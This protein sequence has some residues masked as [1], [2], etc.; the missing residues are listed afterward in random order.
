MIIPY[1]IGRV[2]EGVMNGVVNTASDAGE[3]AKWRRGVWG[4]VLPRLV[5]CLLDMAGSLITSTAGRCMPWHSGNLA[6]KGG[7]QTLLGYLI[8][9]VHI[10]HFLSTFAL[11]ITIMRWFQR[12]DTSLLLI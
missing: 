1:V 5:F 6:G 10:A 2:D 3:G 12:V 11:K 4:R 9:V 7:N 8:Q